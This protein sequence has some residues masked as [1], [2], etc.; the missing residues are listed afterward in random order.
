MRN[1]EK[2]KKGK[3]LLRKTYGDSFILFTYNCCRFGVV[4][5]LEFE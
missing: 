2:L 3:R 1:V 4:Q 5:L